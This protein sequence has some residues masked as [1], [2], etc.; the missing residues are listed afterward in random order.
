[1]TDKYWQNLAKEDRKMVR[2]TKG[3][4]RAYYRAKA[5]TDERMAKSGSRKRRAT[6]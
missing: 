3:R 4:R 6:K 2:S 1:M 5:R